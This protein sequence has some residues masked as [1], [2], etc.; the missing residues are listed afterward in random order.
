MRTDITSC[1]EEKIFC[2]IASGISPQA[3]ELAYRRPL[4]PA[5]REKNRVLQNP[6][7]RDDLLIVSF[8]AGLAVPFIDRLDRQR[9]ASPARLPLPFTPIC[10]ERHAQRP[11]VRSHGRLGFH[12]AHPACVFTYLHFRLVE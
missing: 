5:D 6:A 7:S 4:I 10:A 9:A 3:V 1:S 12:F 11:E 8:A 2:F